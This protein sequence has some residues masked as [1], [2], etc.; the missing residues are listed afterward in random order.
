[1][2]PGAKARLKPQRDPIDLH[3]I[4]GF[5]PAAAIEGTGRGLDVRVRQPQN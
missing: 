4:P 1:M 2:G 5:A 3:R